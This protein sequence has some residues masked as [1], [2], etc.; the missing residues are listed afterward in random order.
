MSGDEQTRSRHD[1]HWTTNKPNKILY[2]MYLLQIQPKTQQNTLPNVFRNT[3]VY[4]NIGLTLQHR[5]KD[6]LLVT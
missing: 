2:Q 1:L 3:Y 6:T 4:F 5:F